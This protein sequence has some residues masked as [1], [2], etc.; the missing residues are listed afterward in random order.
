MYVSKGMKIDNNKKIF[1]TTREVST[2][3]NNFPDWLLVLALA[4]FYRVNFE[5]DTLPLCPGHI[6]WIGLTNGSSWK[7]P[8]EE[9]LPVTLE[10]GATI[11]VLD[12]GT[13]TSVGLVALCNGPD[14]VLE[15]TWLNRG[16]S[17][18]RLL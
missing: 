7:P 5:P 11:P 4:L 10:Q 13:W 6:P 14:S 16:F 12:T 9:C 1:T 15:G 18:S 3:M 17:D 8:R 2:T